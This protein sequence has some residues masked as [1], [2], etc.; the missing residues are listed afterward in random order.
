MAPPEPDTLVSL[1]AAWTPGGEGTQWPQL[2]PAS[3]RAGWPRGPPGNLRGTHLRPFGY[4]EKSSLPSPTRKGPGL[5]VWSLEAG[6]GDRR[7]RRRP[8]VARLP[9][10]L[11]LQLLKRQ[12]DP[13]RAGHQ[14]ESRQQSPPPAARPFHVYLPTSG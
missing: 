11:S 1:K 9:A 7:P 8:Q 6:A 13:E 14:G 12:A 2:G 4:E 10:A 5:W 3:S